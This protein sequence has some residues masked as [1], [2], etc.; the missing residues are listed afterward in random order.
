[1]R[2]MRPGNFPEPM[3][4]RLN[5]PRR[6]ANP[7]RRAERG[8]QLEVGRRKRDWLARAVALDHVRRMR[9]VTPREKLVLYR[10]AC[11]I[12]RKTQTCDPS[13]A[14]LAEDC[15][16]S[17]RTV[18]RLVR[19]LERKGILS[20]YHSPGSAHWATTVYRFNPELNSSGDIPTPDEL[21]ERA[22]VRAKETIE[23]EK[24]IKW[25]KCTTNPF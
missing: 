8:K 3:R 22:K 21:L 1:M 24:R 10:L 4:T 9:N 5:R 18:I 23:P 14:T 13:Y 12:D 15:A 19:E 16:L 11:R 7:E 2:E 25:T 6:D 17:R 20:D